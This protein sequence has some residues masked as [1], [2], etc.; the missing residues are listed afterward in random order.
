MA[1]VAHELPDILHDVEFG[2]SWQQL[3]LGDV[4]RHGEGGREVPSCVVQK[5]H[6]VA[7]G[8]DHGGDLG[9][10]QAHRLGVALGQ[11]QGG[12][13]APLR[14]DGAEDVGGG[15]ALVLRRHWP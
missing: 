1:V 6:G 13:L 9:Q 11:H 4:G 5:Q 12:I 15:I 7:A 10:V 3:Q 14:A 2:Q 8:T